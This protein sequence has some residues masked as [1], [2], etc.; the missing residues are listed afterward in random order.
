M[1]LFCISAAGA[2]P[3]MSWSASLRK[4]IKLCIL[5]LPGRGSKRSEKPVENMDELCRILISDMDKENPAND[6]FMILGYCFGAVI[7]YEIC[8][9]LQAENKPLPGAFLT[10]G[11]GA[12]DSLRIPEKELTET[13]EFRGMVAQFFNSGSLGSDEAAEKAVSAYASA[14]KKETP[15]SFASVFPDGNEDEDFEQ[16]Q[17]LFLL[18]GAME[19]ISQDHRMLKAYHDAAHGHEVIKTCAVVFYSP[20]DRFAAEKDVLGW[21]RYFQSSDKKSVTG[22]HYAIMSEKKFFI[23]IINGL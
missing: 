2:N 3:F 4:D 17:L 16:M 5:D 15:V 8:K 18:N 1:I 21:E 10:F 23:E 13:E 12:P 11:S 7:A 20:Q 19:Q 14:Y 6:S 9:K 22:G